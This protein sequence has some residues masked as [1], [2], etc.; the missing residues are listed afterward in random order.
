MMVELVNKPQKKTPRAGTFEAGVAMMRD[1]MQNKGV[2]RYFA[3]AEDPLHAAFLAKAGLHP[4][5]SGKPLMGEDAR[6]TFDSLKNEKRTGKGL[7]YIHV[8][9]CETRCLY[10]MFYQNPLS[11]EESRVFTKALIKDLA[12]WEKEN[13]QKT[14]LI[15]ALYFGGGTPT[16][17]MADD[18]KAILDACK[19]YLPLA[20]DCE[21]TLEGRIFNFGDDKIEAALAGGVNRFSLG[22]QTFDSK[23]R[24]SVLRVDGKD[25]IIRRLLKMLS[26]DNAAVVIDLI[27]GF[28]GQTMAVWED[29]V[30]TAAAL[31]LD[32]VDCYQLNVFNQ[33]P[34]A[35]YIENGNLPAAADTAQKA[36]MFARSIEI[37][38]QAN[39]QRISNQHW[40]QTHRERN[41]YNELAKGACDMLAFGAGGGGRLKGH[42]FMMERQLKTWLDLVNANERPVGFLSLPAKNGALLNTL[43][44]QMELGSVSFAKLEKTFNVPLTEIFEPITN[45]W[46]EAGLLKQKGEWFY[47]TVAGQFWHVTMAQ[48][49]LD[50]IRQHFANV[51]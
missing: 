42:S 18:L 3:N 51:E 30:K 31:P 20:N 8:P 36:D 28:P 16:A 44:S 6:A 4:G 26:Y 41:I 15:H 1:S 9:F 38:T 2:E 49:L 29:D 5:G 19:K 37:L 33:S 39:W 27:Y 47:Q 14:G 34:M 10:C 46:I 25:E 7:A 23:V 11:D 24:Q 40:R 50:R 45:Q 43:S 12:A 35:K 22:V 48:M 32:G 21:I 13:A 17:L